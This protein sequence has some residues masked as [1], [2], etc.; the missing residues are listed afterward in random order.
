MAEPSLPFGGRQKISRDSKTKRAARE[1]LAR[2]LLVLTSQAWVGAA[3][4]EAVPEAWHHL[5]QDLDV[6]ERKEKVTLYLDR[7]VAQFYRAMGKG[8]QARINRLLA[9]WAQMKIAEEIRHEA[10]VMTWLREAEEDP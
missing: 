7:S 4:R 1:G 5:E 2:N 8:Y 9:T 3:L 6:S 10:D